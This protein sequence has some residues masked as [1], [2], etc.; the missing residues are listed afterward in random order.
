MYVNDIKTAQKPQ[1]NQ[2]SFKPKLLGSESA[3]SINSPVDP[4]LYLQK[5]VISNQSVCRM[6]QAK[7]K[8]GHPNVNYEQEADWVAE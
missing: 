4:I 6:L 8:I 2:S 5:S 1:N 3:K 7:L